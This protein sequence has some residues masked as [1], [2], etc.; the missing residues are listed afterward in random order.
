MT[1]EEII[2][3]LNTAETAISTGNFDLAH[4]L[5]TQLRNEKYAENHRC[6]IDRIIGIVAMKRG[7]YPSALEYL[8]EA[9]AVCEHS[10]EQHDVAELTDIIGSIYRQLAN[11][12]K[13]LEY[14]TKALLVCEE[15]NIPAGVIRCTGNIGLVYFHLADYSKALEYLSRTYTSYEKLGMK[16]GAATAL[17]NMGAVY[18]NLPDYPKALECYDT[19]L[20]INEE[21]GLKP[22]VALITGNMG[23]IYFS[24]QDYHQAR[25]YLERA[26]ALY[27][28]LGMK[29]EVAR[30]IH[31][32]GG[33]YAK[34]HNPMYNVQKAEE[35]LWKAVTINEELGTKEALY[36]NYQNLAMLYEQ[37][38]RWQQALEHYKK[39]YALEKEVHNQEV[40]RNAELYDAERKTVEKEKQLALAKEREHILNNILP[41]DITT[42]LINGENPIADHF[43]SVSILFM[44]IIKFT[45]LSAK[46]SARQLVYLLNHIFTIADGIMREFGL[47]K[48]KTIG[49]AYMAVAG[50]PV[51][52]EDH[53]QRAALA[54]LKLLNTMQNLVVTFP[55]EYSDRSWIESLSEIQ[56]RIG[57][58]CG[59]A[60]AGVV[61]E[62]KFLYDLWGDAVNTASRMESHGEAGK[63]HC[64]EEFV[65]QLTMDNGKWIMKQDAEKILLSIDNYQLSIIPRGEMEIKGKGTMR[66][67]WLEKNV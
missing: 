64:S 65:N 20:R 12:A 1:N 25:E 49:D 55:A 51:V 57:L 26:L 62:N 37:D 15:H 8:N 42:R 14:Y 40:K 5:A 35:Y 59:P 18:E 60:A 38:E 52:Q 41:E 4:I 56:V 28:E 19:A 13:A 54:A 23:L 16:Q 22:N 11:Y 66:T 27:Q 34:L 6:D 50:A 30:M 45:E 21:L 44:D 53:A 29:K 33:Y 3:N 10:G 63:I 48:I 9:L 43:D 47:E 24:V 39:Y 2:E 61:G 67:Y 46:I 58:H 36:M 32:L 7:D 17:S 31:N